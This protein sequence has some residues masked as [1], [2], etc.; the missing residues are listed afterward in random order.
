MVAHW[1]LV[2]K[3]IQKLLL[4]FR[5]GLGWFRNGGHD[6]YSRGHICGLTT[7]VE[8][9]DCSMG[10]QVLVLPLGQTFLD[11]LSADVVGVVG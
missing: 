9:K 8:G 10:S 11:F 2:S 1:F 3:K 4:W 5:N 7:R 6:I